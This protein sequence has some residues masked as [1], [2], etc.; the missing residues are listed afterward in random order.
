MQRD[1]SSKS[2]EREPRTAVGSDGRWTESPTTEKRGATEDEHD[3]I[4][5]M[6]QRGQGRTPEGD[7][8]TR[9]PLRVTRV[10]VEEAA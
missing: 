5:Q 4:C 1:S 10:V 8:A 3:Q 2:L 6:L 7:L 9:R